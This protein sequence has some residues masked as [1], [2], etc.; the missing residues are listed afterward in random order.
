MNTYQINREGLAQFTIQECA[1]LT[2]RNDDINIKMPT[3][4]PPVINQRDNIRFMR[5]GGE[6]YLLGAMPPRA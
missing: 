5:T 3:L 4:T 1:M 2:L 6:H